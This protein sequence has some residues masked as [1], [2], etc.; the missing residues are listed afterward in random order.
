MTQSSPAAESES[1]NPT[2]TDS[3][4][5]AGHPRALTTL[6]FTE[7]WERFSFYGMKA[8][9]MLYMTAPLMY[10]GMELSKT[11]GGIILGNYASSVYLTPLIGGWLA[12]T[13]L[14]TRLAVLFGGIIIAAGHF[15][16]AVPSTK[17]FY[18]GLVLISLGTGLLKPNM[19][20]MVGQLY[21]PG[22]RRRD[23]GFSIFY[24]GVNLGAFIAPLV[25]GFLAQSDTFKNVIKSMGANPENSWH[26]AF[27]A[28][29]IGMVLGLV[30]YVIGRPR[31]HG[32]GEPPKRD[33]AKAESKPKDFVPII[34][35]AACAVAVLGLLVT[36]YGANGL[37]FSTAMFPTV[38]GAAL[39]YMIGVIRLLRGDELHRVMA[40]LIL[41]VF[42]II[43]WATFEQSAGSLTIFADEQTRNTVLGHKFPSSWYQAIQPLF[44]I[45]LAPVFAWLWV[46]L[47]RRDPSSPVKFGFGLLFSGLAF[48]LMALATTFAGN[49]NRVSPMWLVGCYLIQTLGELCLSPVGL[50]TVTK[51]S[52]A[53]LAG[54]M[55]SLWF[56]ATA[57]GDFIA[58]WAV[59]FVSETEQL[60][61]FTIC[62]VVTLIAAGLL[63][64]ISPMINRLVRRTD[65]GSPERGFPVTLSDQNSSSPQ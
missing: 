56:L 20:T 45:A 13:Y 6:F 58:G 54:L 39:G 32:V 41:F 55:M 37:K 1:S 34:L 5:I 63:F 23:A 40:I 35:A 11:E 43:F 3:D 33:P 31:L 59:R 64:G 50:S 47:G 17:T 53:R 52:P 57:I 14:G 9:L 36:L 26:W 29:G 51:L 21:T 65:S 12:D 19:S 24:M 44:V 22:D 8:I 48:A 2:T 46:R 42:S 15:S 25:C 30:Q 7:M 4:G 61:L 10:G 18:L 60:K 28:A 38:L 62:A 16:M 27:A 49:G